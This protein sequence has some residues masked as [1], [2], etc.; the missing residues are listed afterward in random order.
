MGDMMIKKGAA[1]PVNVV[2]Q[3]MTVAV[4]FLFFLSPSSFFLGGR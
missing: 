4:F 2:N 3:L 1:K